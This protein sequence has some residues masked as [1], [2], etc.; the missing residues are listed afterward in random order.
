MTAVDLLTSGLS[1]DDIAD[2]LGVPKD[3]GSRAPRRIPIVTETQRGTGFDPSQMACDVLSCGASSPLTS[4]NLRDK[5]GAVVLNRGAVAT[6][7][8][9]AAFDGITERVRAR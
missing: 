6:A 5:N 9:I 2:K 8:A 3:F 7:E 4:A 1:R